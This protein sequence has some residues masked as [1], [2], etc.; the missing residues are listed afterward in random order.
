MGQYPRSR[1]DNPSGPTVVAN[2]HFPTMFHI[3]YSNH[4]NEPMKTSQKWCGP[5][6][7]HLAG[8]MDKDDSDDL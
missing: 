7:A 6:V 5:P 2:T 1:G 4:P 8:G 3:G